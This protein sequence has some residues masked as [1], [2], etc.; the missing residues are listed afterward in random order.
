MSSAW[1]VIQNYPL[2]E[3]NRKGDVKEVLTGRKLVTSRN[4]YG[5][6]YHLESPSG[7][8]VAVKKADLITWEFP[9][10]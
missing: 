9:K 5:E 8:I 1:R 4:K 6:H 2:Y 10:E 3:V 7:R